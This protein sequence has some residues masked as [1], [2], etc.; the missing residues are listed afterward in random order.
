MAHRDCDLALRANALE[1][2]QNVRANANPYLAGLYEQASQLVR[3]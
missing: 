1:T 3:R 2:A